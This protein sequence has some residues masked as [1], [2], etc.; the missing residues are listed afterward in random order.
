MRAIVNRWNQE[1][2]RAAT[3]LD[4]VKRVHAIGRDAVRSSP[5]DV[6]KLIKE[7]MAVVAKP[8]KAAGIKPE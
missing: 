5:E 8:A 6:E 4:V 3:A 7:Q 1:V 2:R